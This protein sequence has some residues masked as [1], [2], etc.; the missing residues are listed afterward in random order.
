MIA[1]CHRCV[2]DVVGRFN[3]FIAKYMG[4]GV[5]AYFGFP[6]AHEDDAER[7]V[8][9]GLEIARAVVDLDSRGSSLSARI[10]IATGL[11]V[12]GDLGSGEAHAVVGE[13][14]NLAA[15]LQAEAPPSGVVIDRVT[16]RLGGTWF[17]YRDLGPHR[18]KGIA[19]PVLLTQAL[20][21]RAVESRF[22]ALRSAVQTPFV[23]REQEIG[24]LTDR[25]HMASEGEVFMPHLG[26]SPMPAQR[27]G[28][29]VVERRRSPCEATI[30]AS[31]ALR[32]SYMDNPAAV[33]AN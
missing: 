13:I 17:L 14:P 21:E 4:D 28:E 10:G 29:G 19:E 31:R 18:L 15:R 26:H 6:A 23:G 11:V 30:T 12:V 3:G 33:P 22:A 9:A 2:A 8:R 32:I 25:W 16:R 24:L 7:A 27:S 1:A 5:L 20:R